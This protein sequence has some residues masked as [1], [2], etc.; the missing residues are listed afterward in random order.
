MYVRI[1]AYVTPA[2]AS[3]GIKCLFPNCPKV[4]TS[5]RNMRTHYTLKH[6]A[7]SASP[8]KRPRTDQGAED[9][10]GAYADGGE[11]EDGGLGYDYDLT[12]DVDAEHDR[13]WRVPEDAKDIPL[14][15]ELNTQLQL[16][17][18]SFSIDCQ[19]RPSWV[20]MNQTAA[21]LAQLECL[22]SRD[23]VA[24][25]YH[26]SMAAQENL[27]R[28]LRAVKENGDPL[29]VLMNLQKPVSAQ[30]TVM[31]AAVPQYL[32]SVGGPLLTNASLEAGKMKQ[33]DV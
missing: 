12:G 19:P 21:A 15:A 17:N 20:P 22:P 10:G 29:F 5:L 16:Y 3:A 23:L 30:R 32:R 1:S 7:D 33:V 27:Q 18:S 8:A 25:C 4:C 24:D 13:S 11:H 14:E 26:I 2:I 28:R 31:D 9:A 6:V